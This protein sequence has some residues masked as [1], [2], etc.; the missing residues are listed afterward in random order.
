VVIFALFFEF[1]NGFHDTANSV[2]TCVG[3]RS[4][5]VPS[6]LTRLSCLQHCKE[7][8]PDREKLR[9][10]LTALWSGIFNFLPAFVA[11]LAVAN[12]ISGVIKYSSFPNG[13]FVPLGVLCTYATL[14][15]AIFWNFLTWTFGLPSSSSHALIG[16]LVGSGLAVGG[17]KAITWP[18]LEAIVYGLLGSP[19]YAGVV[20]IILMWFLN[21]CIWLVLKCKKENAG[22]ADRNH[23]VYRGLTIISTAGLGWMH[24]SNDAQ[25][26]MGVIGATLLA[27]GYTGMNGKHV[28]IPLWVIFACNIVI[29]I[30]TMF[31]GWSIVAKMA[32][33]IY[34]GLQR[35]SAICANA[36]AIAAIETAT[37]IGL[38]V[39][40]THAMNSAILLAGIGDAGVKSVKWKEMGKM[41]ICWILTIPTTIFLGFAFA[42]MMTLPGSWSPFFCVF[43]GCV[44]VLFMLFCL[45]RQRQSRDKAAE[46]ITQKFKMPAASDD[47][48]AI[49]LKAA[50]DST[51][52]SPNS[53]CQCRDPAKSA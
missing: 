19:A 43:W 4:F 31:G 24:G 48:A 21:F 25:K 17:T 27:A 1:S 16:A 45:Y 49:S 14:L 52:T 22:D 29:A 10:L 11:P 9:S 53:S 6:L 3:T 36:G 46:R 13:E 38:P 7:E 39:S 37:A 35:T 32:L 30:G 8:G 47:P 33:D 18:Q 23:W 40:T 44:L 12:T 26:T 34:P 42:S 2:A 50:A 15:G 20:A 28:V 41:L 5:I 51:N